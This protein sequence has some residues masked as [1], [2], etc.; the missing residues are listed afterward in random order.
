MHTPQQAKKVLHWGLAITNRHWWLQSR[1]CHKSLQ[2][3]SLGCAQLFVS[4]RYVSLLTLLHSSWK[5]RQ[6]WRILALSGSEVFAKRLLKRRAPSCLFFYFLPSCTVS[7][8]VLQEQVQRA[9][10]HAPQDFLL[11]CLFRTNKSLDTAV[12]CESCF[13]H[14]VMGTS[15]W[16]SAV[17]QGHTLREDPSQCRC[18]ATYTRTMYCLVPYQSKASLLPFV[19][20]QNCPCNQSPKYTPMHSCVILQASSYSTS[21]LIIGQ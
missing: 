18:V 15:F 10:R 5:G 3:D 9:A 11:S 6:S 13:L 8:F 12:T 19:Y 4:Y 20:L 17:L 14:S 21:A 7:T 2:A 16:C 1:L